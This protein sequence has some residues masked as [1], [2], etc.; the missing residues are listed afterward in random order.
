MLDDVHCEHESSTREQYIRALVLGLLE[1]GADAFEQ[2]DFGLESHPLYRT[3]T[4]VSGRHMYCCCSKN[5]I[6]EVAGQGLGDVR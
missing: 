4:G 5:T 2:A 1:G 6:Q 3:I